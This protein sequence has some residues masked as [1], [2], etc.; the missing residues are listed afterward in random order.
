[1]NTPDV[2][3]MKYLGVALTNTIKLRCTGYEE[4][5]KSGE[6]LLKFCSE[7]FFR[8]VPDKLKIK[9]PVFFITHRSEFWFPPLT[10]GLHIRLLSSEFE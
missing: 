10:S 8:V 3:K 5:I 4:K 9:I 7:F 1:M 6:N 2:P